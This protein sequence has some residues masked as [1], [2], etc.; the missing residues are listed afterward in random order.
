M[1]MKYQVRCKKCGTEAWLV[2]ETDPEDDLLIL[3]DDL[4]NEYCKCGM[5]HVDILAEVDEDE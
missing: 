2:G 5:E 4:P 3:R 1:T